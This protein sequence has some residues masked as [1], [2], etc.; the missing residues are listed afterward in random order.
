M[1]KFIPKHENQS[2]FDGGTSPETE[3]VSSSEENQKPPEEIKKDKRLQWKRSLVK[4]RHFSRSVAKP[5][6]GPNPLHH[7]KL[8]W[9]ALGVSGSAIAFGSGWL[10]L[11]ASLPDSLDDVLTYVRDDT[12]TIKASDG[13]IIQQTGPTTYENLRLR[14]IP[15]P[16]VQ[17]FISIEDRRFYQHNGVDY[18][19]IL[20]AAV[21]NLKSGS[22]VEGAST[23]TQQLTRIVFLDQEKSWLRKLK[24]VRLAQK[25]ESE[26]GKDKI[27]ER[28]FNLVYLGEGAYGVAD[29][30]WVYF[31]KRV[32]ELTLPEIA[33]LAGIPPAPN[34]YSPIKNSEVAKARRDYVLQRMQDANYITAEEAKA[35]IATP[36][37][38]N[39]SPPKRLERK[40]P[41]FSDYVLQ[42]LPQYISK[43]ALEVKGLTIETSLK[44]EW[45]E[46]AESAVQRTLK[47]S[48]RYQRFEQAAL[49]AIDPRNGEI[50]AMVGGKDFFEQQ[51]NR[52]TQ[53][54][55]QPGS[56]FK[57]FLYTTAIATGISPFRGYLDAEYVVDGYEP[58]NYGDT[59]RGWV[60]IR[61]ALISSVNIVAV[62][63]LIDVGW[64]PTIEVAKKM[65]IESELKPTY[66][67]AL[68]ASEVN[69]L[70][71]TSAYGTLAAKGMHVKPYGIRR[72]LDR[73]GNV[74]YEAKSKPE[75][76]I[77]AETSA[78]MTWML[79]GVVTSGTGSPAQIGRPVAGKTGTSDEARD[80]WFVG[81]IPQLVTGVWLGNDDNQPTWGASSTA[82]ATWRRFMTVA[83]E[84]MDTQEFPDRPTK[85]EGRKPTIEAKPIKPKRARSTRVQRRSKPQPTVQRNTQ[86]TQTRPARQR[87]RVEEAAPAPAPQRQTQRRRSRPTNNSAPS[88]APAPAPR[89]RQRAATPPPA[90]P[91]PRS[92]PPAPRQAPPAAPAPRQAAPAPQP[93]AAP[94]PAPRLERKFEPIPAAAPPAPPASRKAPEPAAP[95]APAPE[96]V[97]PV[98]A[99]E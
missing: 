94:A 59:F 36:L 73:Q 81:Y 23:I 19:G 15:K 16:L 24:E 35:A 96:A 78:I 56:T 41:Y 27:L 28:Y 45:Q 68:G 69:L 85:L 22:V 52:V 3:E 37:T 12:V 11:E 46:A 74:I 71:L 7:R 83:T 9:L 47:E 62:K 80:L 87:R 58:K 50:R 38:T 61:D 14:E 89:R 5:F 84:E 25:I 44:P 64:E 4:L 57:T 92:A 99:V 54:K 79:Q 76:A 39:P 32:G 95:P 67:L 17:A 20:R 98:E 26:V 42:E 72:I 82:A 63:T 90:A 21:S 60:N 33:M 31:S 86:Q 2:N 91:A 49:V 55:R 6:R 97:A 66:S 18:Q 30:A 75:R 77:D 10:V 13:T 40:A 70:E 1:S 48:G 29:A 43:E 51:F 65:G 8:F 34:D 53:A 93:A 88:Q